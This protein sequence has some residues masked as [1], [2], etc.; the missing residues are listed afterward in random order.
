[1]G[2]FVEY[3]CEECGY[4]FEAGMGFGF[5]YPSQFQGAVEAARKGQYGREYRR[6]ILFHEKVLGQIA[7]VDLTRSI[8]QCSHC[9][10]YHAIVD[11]TLYALPRKHYPGLRVW[12]GSQKEY[13]IM[14][15]EMRAHGKVIATVDHRCQDCGGGLRVIEG[16]PA[17]LPCPKCGSVM[18]RKLD[19]LWD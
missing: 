15:N 19:A 12:T 8:A 9:G 10:A 1:M 18:L 2:S 3:E 14:P 6:K 11:N 7:A 4:S 16:E 13:F 17:Q 5:G